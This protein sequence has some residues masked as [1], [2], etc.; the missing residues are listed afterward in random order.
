MGRERRVRCPD[1]GANIDVEDDLDIG[2]TT[3]CPRCDAEL[4]II[5]VD[6]LSVESVGIEEDGLSGDD[7]ADDDDTGF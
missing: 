5:E 7:F 4:K 6:P 2:D 1:C 3:V